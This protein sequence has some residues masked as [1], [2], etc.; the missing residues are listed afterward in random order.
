M[1]VLSGG[2]IILFLGGRDDPEGAVHRRTSSARTCFA[3]ALCCGVLVGREPAGCSRVRAALDQLGGVAA[4]VEQRYSSSASAGVLQPS[5]LRGRPLSVAA[6]AVRFSAVCLAK[7]VP[8]GKY[9]RSR[10]LV[11]SFVPLS[12]RDFEGHRNILEDRCRS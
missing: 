3:F 1:T 2:V 6:T 8:F 11:F 5:V 10:P 7:S 12:A 4:A 9:C